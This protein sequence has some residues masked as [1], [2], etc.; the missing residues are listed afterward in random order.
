M[1]YREE[2]KIYFSGAEL[3]EALACFSEMTNIGFPFSDN[4]QLSL[5][6]GPELVAT[7]CDPHDSDVNKEFLESEVTV[8]LVLLCKKMNIPIA[9]KA[10]KSVEASDDRIVLVMQ[11]VDEGAQG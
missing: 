2:R 5:R 9:R 7:L 8:A 4:A 3:I 6:T 10:R 1:M 11:L